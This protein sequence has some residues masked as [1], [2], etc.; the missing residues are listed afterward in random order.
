MPYVFAFSPDSMTSQ[1]YDEIIQRLAAAG[2]GSPQGRIYHACYG[3]AESLRVFDVW[4]SPE[5]FEQFGQTLRP[6]LQEIGVDAGVPEVTPVH[7][8]I[9]G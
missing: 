8:V 4:D 3:P 5:S 6:I 1:K 7:N 2:A 9:V